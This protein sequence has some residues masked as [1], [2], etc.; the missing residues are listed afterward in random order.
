MVSGAIQLDAIVSNTPHRI[1]ITV[2]NHSF[3]VFSVLPLVIIRPILSSELTEVVIESSTQVVPFQI[4]NVSTNAVDYSIEI[5]CLT[6]N[7]SM[8]VQYYSES[9]NRLGLSN[10]VYLDPDRL[11]LPINIEAIT[12]G[13]IGGTISIDSA[14]ER[15]LELSL[16]VL[17]SEDSNVVLAE[18]S[19]TLDSGNSQ[20]D[21]EIS[22]LNRGFANA[23]LL[24]LQCT[25][26]Y[27]ESGEPILFPEALTSNEDHQ[28]IDFVF[29]NLPFAPVTP[30]KYL[31]LED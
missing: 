15:D 6:C 27:R 2:R 21:Y 30:I 29:E 13:I 16:F 3:V 5:R 8:P 24:R 10:D 23:W 19:L 14:A 11:D 28:G 9:G 26:C 17:N 31:I 22:E 7:G 25:N 12:R 4:E 18:K 1:Q 20:I